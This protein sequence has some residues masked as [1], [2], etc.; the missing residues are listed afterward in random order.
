[1]HRDGHPHAR[2]GARQL[3][4]HEDVRDE[5]GA[6]AAKLLGHAHP[7][8]AEL[9]ELCEELVWEAVLPVPV[10]GVRRDLGVGDLAGER[11]D[12]PLLVGQGEV[13][14]GSVGPPRAARR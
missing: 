12:L 5:V 11:L 8:Q 14:G 2:V 6:R 1:V 4:E 7:H 3:L 13:H 9:A 10:R